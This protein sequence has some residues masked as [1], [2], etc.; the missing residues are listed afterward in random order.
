[1]RYL[2]FVAFCE[3][4]DLSSLAINGTLS[5]DLDLGWREGQLEVFR[6]E[7]GALVLVLGVKKPTRGVDMLGAGAKGGELGWKRASKS[8]V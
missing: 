7:E 4:R 2:V 8:V 3:E 5:N 6:G 1:M